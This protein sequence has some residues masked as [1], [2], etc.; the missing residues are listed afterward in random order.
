MVEEMGQMLSIWP[1]DTRLSN[2]PLSQTVSVLSYEAF[3]VVWK[4]VTVIQ[5]FYR[6][7]WVAFQF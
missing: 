3:L 4:E 1:Q 7:S 2:V 5:K 6:K